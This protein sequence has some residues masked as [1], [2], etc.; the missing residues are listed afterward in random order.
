MLLKTFHASERYSLCLFLYFISEAK[1][2]GAKTACSQAFE[3]SKRP[4]VISELVTDRQALH[5][6]E[7]FLGNT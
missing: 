5:A 1:C 4:N 2:L 7:L 3:Y 6:A